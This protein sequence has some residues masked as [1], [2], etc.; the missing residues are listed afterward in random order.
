MK[1]TDYIFA[2]AKVRAIETHLI[3]QNELDSV[4]AAPDYETAVRLL[5][6]LGFDDLDESNEERVLQEK[7]RDAL[8]FIRD[9]APSR[10]A[11]DF[12]L[13]KHDFHNM[14]A[15]LKGLVT[16][17]D[18]HS[19]L[20]EP[21]LVSVS[22]ME[23]A[24]RERRYDSLPA[25]AAKALSNGYRLLAETMDGQQLDIWLDAVSLDTTLAM[26]K[27]SGDAFS[28]GLAETMVCLTNIKVAFRGLKTGKDRT[29]FETALA[30][31]DRLS[32][33]TLITAALA[34]EEAFIT[35]L[36]ECGYTTLARSLGVSHSAF[37]R[38]TDN[39]LMDYVKGA[40]YQSF[41][42]A[43]LIGYYFARK[44]E[45]TSIRI[46]LCGKRNGVPE[47]HIRERM[48]VLYG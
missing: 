2:V 44:S 8:V 30:E 46:L 19:F 27:Q 7:L 38:E 22:E 4:V 9:I 12:L 28:V 10:S 42:I 35:C 15:C 17:I 33:D 39:R 37:E 45:L 20:I 31:S 21:S 48:R 29:F 11:L 41:G 6:E 3:R 47:Q 14:K 16:D 18:Y 23:T 32:K 36:Q 43:P 40:R 5:R 26:A 24:I 25:F 34:G 13:V 1:E